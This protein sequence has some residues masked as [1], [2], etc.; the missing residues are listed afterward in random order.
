[1][2]QVIRIQLVIINNEWNAIEKPV[3]IWPS[4]FL[5]KTMLFIPIIGYN[6]YSTVKI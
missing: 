2:L 3:R 5:H 6:R 1:M 4:D